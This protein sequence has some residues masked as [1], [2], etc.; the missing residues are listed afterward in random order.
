MKEST[1][2]NAVWL[3][4]GCGQFLVLSDIVSK[5]GSM[6]YAFEVNTKAAEHATKKA[7]SMT[8]VAGGGIEVFTGASTEPSVMNQFKSRLKTLHFPDVNIIFELFGHFAS[9][10]GVWNTMR[11]LKESLL[12]TTCNFVPNACATFAT[13]VHVHDNPHGNLVLLPLPRSPDKWKFDR[14]SQEMHPFERI[15]FNQPLYVYNKS[16]I[17]NNTLLFNVDRAGLF[18]GLAC[19]INVYFKPIARPDTLFDPDFFRRSKRNSFRP[20]THFSNYPGKEPFPKCWH[21]AM[22]ILNRPIAVQKGD[23]IIVST[24]INIETELPTYDFDFKVT[25]H[26]GSGPSSVATCSL[27]TDD[28]FPNFLPKKNDPVLSLSLCLSTYI[29]YMHYILC[30]PTC[31]Y[32]CYI[33]ICFILSL[34]SIYIY[35]YI[36]ICL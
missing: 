27:T 15:D 35:V 14:L 36:Y 1:A 19:F 4:V 29:Y 5:T 7:K 22:V 10:E 28:L 33:Y 8:F 6:V 16:G 11:N 24:R 21:N 32:I 12:Q 30:L 20:I 25:S 9:S 18:N 17:Q 3:D 34:Q 13:P 23:T 2:P 26:M 31:I